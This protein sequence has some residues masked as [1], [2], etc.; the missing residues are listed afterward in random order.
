MRRA[1]AEVKQRHYLALSQFRSTISLAGAGTMVSCVWEN[2]RRTTL[3]DTD[4]SWLIDVPLR[5]DGCGEE[6][7]EKVGRLV[8]RLAAPCPKCWATVDFDA[9]KWK[10]YIQECADA[11]HQIAAAY[12]ALRHAR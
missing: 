9:E 12:D 10:V 11:V 6:R 8:Q 4:L 7:I 1:A 5:C 2:A 3:M